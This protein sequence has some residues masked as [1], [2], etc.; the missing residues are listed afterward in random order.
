MRRQEGFVGKK[1][2]IA[3][4]WRAID[5]PFAA[6][7]DKPCYG[8]IGGTANIQRDAPMSARAEQDQR[9]SRAGCVR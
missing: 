7:V 9:C 5:R 2:V 3:Q 8:N 6:N 1:R 4:H